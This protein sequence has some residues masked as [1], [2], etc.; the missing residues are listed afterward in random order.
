MPKRPNDELRACI[1]LLRLI[2]HSLISSLHQ[3]LENIEMSLGVSE[4]FLGQG[5]QGRVAFELGGAAARS[6]ATSCS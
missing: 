4:D 1:R 2:H 5:V 3:F 6:S